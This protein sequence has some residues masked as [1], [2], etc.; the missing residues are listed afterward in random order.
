MEW[1]VD[2]T[3]KK[4]MFAYGWS[5]EIPGR[6]D[7]A[8]YV[9][10]II[11]PFGHSGEKRILLSSGLDSIETVDVHGNRISKIDLESCYILDWS[12]S[13]VAKIRPDA[14]DFAMI[15]K[16]GRFSCVEIE[17]SKLRWTLDLSFASHL[18][19]VITTADL[20]GDGRDNFLLS[21]STGDLVAVDEK[22]G[23]GFVM[24]KKRFDAP[25][26]QAFVA[27]VG[28]DG[29]GDVVA[30]FTNGFVRILE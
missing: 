15:D 19:S 16:F 18:P 9:L 10:P 29:M 1:I 17:T 24:W 6:H 2:E 11:G 4:K 3:G 30:E 14:W 12:C 8:K 23:K 25:L 5:L 22:D 26:R 27:D 20:D 21:T 7:G 13:S 28:G